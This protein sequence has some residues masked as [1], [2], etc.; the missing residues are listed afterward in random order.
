MPGTGWL[1]LG[2]ACGDPFGLTSF[3]RASVSP[4]SLSADFDNMSA[5]K[6][7]ETIEYIEKMMWNCLRGE[8]GAGDAL[9]MGTAYPRALGG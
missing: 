9:Q 8:G 4:C 2:S 5:H 3:V 1:R 6:Q 7:R